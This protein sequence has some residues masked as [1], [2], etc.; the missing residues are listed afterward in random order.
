MTCDLR[1]R[2]FLHALQGGSGST[3]RFVH[4][5]ERLRFVARSQGAPPDVLVQESALALSAFRDDPA[6]MVAAC[7]RIIDRHL[8]CTPL[9][10]LCARMLCAP[11][12]MREARAAV[13]EIESDPTAKLLAEALPADASVVIVGWP[14]QAVGALRRRGDLEVLIVDVDGEADEAVRQLQRMD[15]FATAVS[16]RNAATAVAL[17]DLVLLDCF[18]LGPDSLLAPAGSLAA[19]A[20]AQQLGVEVWALAGVGRLMPASMFDALLTRWSG[21]VEP[22]SATAEVV[23]H[24]LVTHCAGVAGVGTVSDSLIATDCPVAPELFRLVG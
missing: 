4:P 24:E 3:L 22:L 1:I 14:E 7:R 19:A 11:D 13:A 18:G 12:P 21:S 15:V 6:G 17:A 10:W 9:W 20:V 23:P 2:L 5:I 16:A 8:T